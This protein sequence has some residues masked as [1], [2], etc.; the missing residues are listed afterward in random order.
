MCLVRAPR[1]AFGD[2]LPSGTDTVSTVEAPV[3]VWERYCQPRRLP[4]VTTVGE[5]GPFLQSR[6]RLSPALRTQ[7]AGAVAPAREPSPRAATQAGAIV[8]GYI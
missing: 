2:A 4:T 3:L 7:R 1:R 6:F 5:T 8:G